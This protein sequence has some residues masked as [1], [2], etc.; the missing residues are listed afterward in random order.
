MHQRLR[1]KLDAASMAAAEHAG[2]AAQTP[3]QCRAVVVY[4]LKHPFDL[5]AVAA[6]AAGT[7]AEDGRLGFRARHEAHN[8]TVHD[9]RH[10]IAAAKP[11]LQPPLA[12]DLARV[13]PNRDPCRFFAVVRDDGDL[14]AHHV[15]DAPDHRMAGLVDL[16]HRHAPVGFGTTT[17]RRR[18]VSAS[19]EEAKLP[20]AERLDA[21]LAAGAQLRRSNQQ[22]AGRRL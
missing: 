1:Q 4:L 5:P 11:P 22:T 8:A 20:C 14:F 10:I 19:G 12:R 13:G 17:A 6:V 7:I 16:V 3:L 9:R 18:I 15:E 2:P 21:R